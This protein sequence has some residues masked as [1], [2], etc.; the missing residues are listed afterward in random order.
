MIF[1]VDILPYL[2]IEYLKSNFKYFCGLLE[3]CCIF[4]IS[5]GSF[6]FSG[7]Y[8]PKQNSRASVAISF[9]KNV[10]SALSSHDKQVRSLL[11]V[12]HK[13]VAKSFL[14][15]ELDCKS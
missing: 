4:L 9:I 10:I 15:N 5:I 14:T 13:N 8:I 6:H 2:G 7:Q 12:R 11:Y 3:M 1:N